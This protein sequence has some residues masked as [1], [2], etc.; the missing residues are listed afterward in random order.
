MESDRK[1]IGIRTG[2]VARL[3]VRGRRRSTASLSPLGTRACVLTR[4]TG[5]ARH[6][7]S[8]RH[9]TPLCSLNVSHCARW[10]SRLRHSL[11]ELLPRLA[12][13]FNRCATRNFHC[14]VTVLIARPRAAACHNV[15]ALFLLLFYKLFQHN[16]STCTLCHFTFHTLIIFELN[17][18]I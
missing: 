15:P 6:A 9:N 13:L 17:R 10:V 12:L 16:H 14:S 3:F 1:L 11:H 5:R 4:T 8:Q 18:V 2:S 7:L